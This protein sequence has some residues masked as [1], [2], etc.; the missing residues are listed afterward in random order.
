MAAI[1]PVVG[2]TT[3]VLPPNHPS[4]DTTDVE[5]RCP[6][7]NAKVAHHDANVIHNHAST[8]EVPADSAQDA[9]QCP[10]LKGANQKGSITDAT[11]PVVGPV[12]AMLPPTHPKLGLKE[13]GEVCPVTNA[14]LGHH[15]GKVHQHPAV[16]KDAPAAKCP[17]AGSVMNP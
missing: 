14:T 11:C 12:S 2:T 10:A 6:V 3:S 13:S 4:Y 1:C 15:E 9:T 17:V 7:T 16:E 5:A 8:P